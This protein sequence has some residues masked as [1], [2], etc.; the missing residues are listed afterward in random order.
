MDIKT[1]IKQIKINHPFTSLQNSKYQLKLAEQENKLP[2]ITRQQR[3]KHIE[4][5][6]R[7]WNPQRQIKL[8]PY[9]AAIQQN[10]LNIFDDSFLKLIVFLV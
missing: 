6:T 8:C 9:F 2:G 7:I 1:M 5:C 3:T 4:K 10:F